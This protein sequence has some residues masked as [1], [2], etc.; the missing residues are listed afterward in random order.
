[1]V[2][3]TAIAT[4]GDAILDSYRT[5]SPIAPLNE[6]GALT[7]DD[8]YAVQQHQVRHWQQQGRRAVGHK[9]GLTSRAIQTQLGVDQPDYGVLLGDMFYGESQL[10]DVS[11]F[12]SPRIEPE[13]SVVLSKDLSGAITTVEALAAIDYGVASLEIIDS[14]IRDWKITLADTIADNASSGGVVLS[15]RAVKLAGVDLVRTGCVLSRNGDVVATGAG[16]AVLGSPLNALV[17]LSRMLGE[18]GVTLKA[19]SV[20][21][22]GSLTNA[23]P[24]AANDSFTADFATFGPVT[25]TFS[26]EAR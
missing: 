2:N 20:V 22:L 19:G 15:S 25:A 12:I 8:A 16:G 17:W 10:I 18:R 6:S 9:I 23:I 11:R 24:V 21:M 3:D 13:I 4:M 5:G 14:R 1:M 26:G 7:L